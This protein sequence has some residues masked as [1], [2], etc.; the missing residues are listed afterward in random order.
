[1]ITAFS[2]DLFG[3]FLGTLIDGFNG[4]EFQMRLPRAGEVPRAQA[5]RE[6]IK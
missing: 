4:N 1:L 3:W 6:D 2:H 5:L